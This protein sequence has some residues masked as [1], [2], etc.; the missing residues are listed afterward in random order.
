[1][2]RFSASARSSVASTTVRGPS[3]YTIASACRPVIR[4]VGVFNTTSTA[5]AVA[6]ARLTA[7]G[8]PG[9][10]ITVAPH[11]SDGPAADATPYQTHTADATAGA[12]IARTT[13]GA[14]IGA[15]MVW[16]FGADGLVIPA[17]A[18][19]AGIG[20]VCPTGT[21]QIL[22]FYIVWDE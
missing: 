13:L 8:T 5:V 4:E 22:D 2:P 14:A 12:E 20:I 1:M 9:A 10:G 19:T 6:L 18:N 11:V 16:T 15:G 17:G 3:L 7:R 21:G